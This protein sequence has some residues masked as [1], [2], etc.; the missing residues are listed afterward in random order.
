MY[1][2]NFV[3]FWCRST[4]LF[5]V[6]LS[7][8]AGSFAVAAD[9][10]NPFATEQEKIAAAKPRTWTA[11]N[12]KFSVEAKL[13]KVDEGKLVLK[14]ADGQEISVPL[15]KLSEADQKYVDNLLGKTSRGSRRKL[16]RQFERGRR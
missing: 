15:D 10:D 1:R 16:F 8:A 6:F 9:P 5:V 14:R 2:R 11:S 3:R 7:L 13:V 12:G 4:F